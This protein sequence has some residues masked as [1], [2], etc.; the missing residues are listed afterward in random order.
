MLGLFNTLNL[1]ARALQ[2][3]QTGVEVAGQNLANA[4]N[5][6]YSR[7]IVQ[8][9]TSIPTP[10]VVG[11]QGTGVQVTAI[12]QVRDA[13]LDA[14]VRGEASVGGYW[15]SQQSALQNAQTQL[16]QFLNLNASGTG[17]TGGTSGGSGQSLSDQLDGLFNAFQSVATDPTS[18]AQRQNLINQAQTLA[19]GLNQAS[20]NLGDLNDGL[21]T[22]IGNDITSANQLLSSIASLNNQIAR[23]TATGG[24]ANDLNDTREQDLENLARLA[25]IQTAANPDGT[26]SVSIGGAQ[27]VSGSQVLDTLQT[28]DAGGGQLQV[29]TA[30]SGTSLTLTGGSIQG[31]IDARDGALASLRNSL[32]A[33]AS[34]LITQVNSTYSLGF[35]LNGGTGADFFS[36]T[37][38]SNIAVNTLLHNDPSLVQAAG[39]SGAPGDNTVALALARLSR[40]S[41]AG[42]N[43][44]TFSGAYAQDVSTFGFA[45]SDATNQVANFNSVNS[46]LLNQRDSVSGV[47]ME[48][49]MSSMITYQYAYQASSKIIT[50]VDQMLQTLVNLKST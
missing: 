50:T 37:D 6:A 1:G 10:T 38:A 25:N 5:P 19:S 24:S 39:V 17:S 3:Q 41:V 36:G 20:Q 27:L 33:L 28:Y 34:N 48:E 12:Q 35:D 31:T 7:Q 29:Q 21:N 47:S 45:L 13:L 4:N 15:N 8:I 16:G 49:E 40:Q 2:A 46:M 42:L 30:T 11:L 32:D 18:I 43:N 23:A 9:Q 14:E 22:A 44:Q 26:I